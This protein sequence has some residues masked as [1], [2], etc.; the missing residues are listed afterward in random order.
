MALASGA[1]FAGAGIANA[2]GSSEIAADLET[3]ATALNGPV[4]V[5]GTA[6]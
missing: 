2:Q 3:A 6:Q 5:S 4:A 1:V